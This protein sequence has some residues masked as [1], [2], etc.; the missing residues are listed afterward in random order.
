MSYGDEEDEIDEAFGDDGDV[1]TVPCSHCGR[2][3]YE[4]AVRC[5]YC[6]EYLTDGGGA[7]R[8]GWPWWMW[9]GLVGAG[10]VVWRWVVG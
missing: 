2:E 7:V 1:D 10:V 4:D 6:G 9:L 5:P 8:R 3:V